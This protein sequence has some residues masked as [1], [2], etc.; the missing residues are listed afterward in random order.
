MTQYASPAPRVP[1]LA[2][3]WATITA[4]RM[5]GA[6]VQVRKNIVTISRE[7]GEYRAWADGEE[8]TV[9]AADSILRGADTRTVI[10]EIIPTPAA[11]RAGLTTWAGD[12][13]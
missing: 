7:G 12:A 10:H 13:A 4:D 3:T 1:A 9:H 5:D 11:M 2:R 6:V 8:I